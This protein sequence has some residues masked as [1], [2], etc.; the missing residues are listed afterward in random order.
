MQWQTTILSVFAAGLIF[1][2]CD[3]FPIVEQPVTTFTIGL[4]T[5][6]GGVTEPCGCNTRPLGGLDRLSGVVAKRKIQDEFGLVFVGDTF[7]EIDNPPGHR[8]EQEHEKASTIANVLGELAPMAVLPGERDVEVGGERLR[9]FLETYRLPIFSGLRGPTEQRFKADSA[10]RM[11]GGHKLGFIGIAGSQALGQ[12]DAYT[13]GALAL[14][15]QGAEIVI[16]LVGLGGAE[17]EALAGQINGVDIIITG[18]SEDVNPPKVIEGSLVVE[19]GDKGQRLGSLTFQMNGTGAFQYFDEGRNEK[20]ALN[21][22]ITR[23]QDALENLEPGPG[24]DVRAVKLAQLQEQLQA[25]KPIPPKGRYVTWGI[26]DITA[27]SRALPWASEILSKYNKSLCKLTLAA[28]KDLNCPLPK[29]EQESF[30]GTQ[31]CRTCHA[32]AFSVYE[33]TAHSHAWKTLED[34]GKDCDVG[35]IG[36]HSVG[37]EK[38]GGYCRLQDAQP[39]ANVG[40]ESCH[41]PAKSHAANP[42]DRSLWSIRFNRVPVE[43]VCTGCHNQSHS[44]AFDFETYR[45]RI[46]GPG[47]G[48]IPALKESP[49][50]PPQ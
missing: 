35:C 18:G 22:R 9:D 27:G 19:A 32:A 39:F 28:H 26:E 7:Y 4:V 14:R 36:C 42:G 43:A 13:Q 40:C 31:T 24:R 48:E 30:A 15:R 20:D 46:L 45:L 37:F 1:G 47:H 49:T 17:G 2:G 16:A 38:A 23:L 25:I 41:G 44:D 50:L 8:V 33:K 12:A 29:S 10:L 21:K 11:I 6:L 34:K 3:D 5:G